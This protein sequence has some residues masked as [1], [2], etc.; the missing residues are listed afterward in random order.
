MTAL[1]AALRRLL[2]EEHGYSLIELMTVMAIMGVVLGGLTT[3]FVSGSKAEYDMN[4]RFQAQ[5]EARAALDRVRRDVHAS[6]CVTLGTNGT[7]VQLLSA[8]SNGSCPGTLLAY[9]CTSTSPT[10]STQY[11]LYRATTVVAQCNTGTL[12]ADHL[13]TNQN[14]FAYTQS[15]GQQLQKLSVDVQ[16]DASTRQTG[17]MYELKDDVVLRNSPRT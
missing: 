11:A 1:T 5:Q 8:T 17:G 9:F 13:T 16:V 12:V 14:V 7:N 15:T 4:V 3:V 2:R 6:G 10:V